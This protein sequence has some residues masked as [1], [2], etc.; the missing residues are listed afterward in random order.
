MSRALSRPASA[1]ITLGMALCILAPSRG[2]DAKPQAQTKPAT[3]PSQLKAGASASKPAATKPVSFMRDVAPILVENCIACHNPRK[4]ES[5]YVMTTFAQFAKGGQQGEG[6]TLEPGKPDE[7]NLIELIR[8]GGEPRMPYKQDPLPAEKIATIE[9]WVAEGAKYDG[10]APTEDWTILLRKTQAVRIPASYPVTVP[11]TALE[12]SQD[13]ST[14]AASGYHEITVWKTADGS[15]ARRLTGLAE[16]IYD[17]AT[18]PD[19]KYLATAS[20]DPGIFGVARLWLAEPGGGGKPVR[21]LVETQD[22]VFAVAFSPDSKRVA[23]AGADRTIRVFEIETGK[24]L[25]QIEDHADWIFAIAFSPDGKRLASASRDKTCKVFDLEK[26][27]SLVTFPGHAQPVYTIAFA[28][29]GKSVASGGEDSRIRIWN[30]DNDG[31]QVREMGGF[32]GTVFRLRYAPDGQ[33][34]VACSADKAVHVFKSTG[35][36]LRKLQGHQDWIYALAVSRDG[37]TLAT[38]SW[39]G[40]VRLWN[41]ADG[42]LLRNFFAAPGYKPDVAKAAA[43]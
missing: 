8:P 11:I 16:R 26:K 34:L 13:G 42:K 40:D 28:P 27:E 23:T 9:R 21:D 24:T 12:F 32:G 3:G 2:D 35:S 7:S 36:S 14:V 4:S 10:N 33:T 37:K 22:V 6:I 20:G 25:A 38:G 30:P 1:L 29:D 5:K 18:S 31:R 15:L 39:D 43:R 17:I 19:G 41:L